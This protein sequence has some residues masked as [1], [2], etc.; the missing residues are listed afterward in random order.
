MGL[1][2]HVA[3]W[4]KDPSTKVGAALV[5]KNNRLI[6]VGFNGFA[7]GIEDSP[8]RLN[9]RNT[10]YQLVLHAEENAILFAPHTYDT[11][12]YTWPLPPCSHCAALIIQAG[13]TKVV[14]PAVLPDKFTLDERWNESWELAKKQFI[15]AMVTVVKAVR[16]PDG[17]HV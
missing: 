4:S 9:D 12:M 10:K 5:N 15:E 16:K 3:Q 17:W 11:T 1:A 6:S 7:R 13:I 2:E 14:C 8:S